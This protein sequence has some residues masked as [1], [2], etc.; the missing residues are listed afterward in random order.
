MSTIQ[1]FDEKKVQRVSCVL[2]T[3]N[4]KLEN[5]KC[6]LGFWC[7]GVYIPSVDHS[8]QEY[9]KRKITSLLK[10]IKYGEQK[11]AITIDVKVL[12]V[13]AELVLNKVQ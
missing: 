4:W 13:G 10:S 8:S 12:G 5:W 1:I 7:V 11:D 3:G 2:E 9:F 6:V